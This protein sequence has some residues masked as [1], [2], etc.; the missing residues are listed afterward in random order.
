MFDID[1]TAIDQNQQQIPRMWRFYKW[2]IA[3]PN[4]QVIFVSA[5]QHS[6][7]ALERTS[8]AL[9]NAGFNVFDALILR[10][11]HMTAM[12][13]KT[14]IRAFFADKLIGCVGNRWH[15]IFD[16]PVVGFSEDQYHIFRCHTKIRIK[17]PHT[18][19]VC[20]TQL[21][22]KFHWCLRCADRN[23]RSCE[24]P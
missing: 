10:P 13:F 7:L 21:Q 12:G 1:G 14:K 18:L 2:I 16:Q 23:I 19:T 24:D 17:V 3:Q 5:R 4:F 15:D 6:D 9:V 22:C 8:T 11:S 20:P